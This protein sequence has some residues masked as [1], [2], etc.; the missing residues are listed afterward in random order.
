MLKFTQNIILLSLS[1][2]Y[3]RIPFLRP[4]NQMYKSPAK[5]QM[6]RRQ[7]KKGA[8][9]LPKS[10]PGAGG[11]ESILFFLILSFLMGGQGIRKIKC[12][13][14]DFRRGPGAGSYFFNASFFQVGFK[15]FLYFHYFLNG[16]GKD[17]W[18]LIKSCLPFSIRKS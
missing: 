12:P 5:Q 8:G 11:G 3:T 17:I 7:K 10:D 16:Q 18:K 4:V 14:T 6:A 9:T 1:T 2:T 13:S 15:Y